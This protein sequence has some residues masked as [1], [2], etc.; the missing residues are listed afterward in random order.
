MH[1]N[2]L[3]LINFRNYSKV[4]LQLSPTINVF[5][6]P[7]GAGKTNLLDALHYVSFTKS[8]ISSTDQENIMH[9]CKF[10]N[11][12]AFIKTEHSEHDVK[13]I[14]Q[15][16]KRKQFIVDDSE[17]EKMSDHIGRFPSV[18]IQPA[19]NDLIRGASALRR[20]FFD[21][22]I[23]QYDHQY[24]EA[25]IRYNQAL[26]QRN[27][28]LRDVNRGA[29]LDEN[30][31]GIYTQHL[32]T[33]GRQIF[34]TRE[35]FLQRFQEIFNSEY[36][37]IS[38]DLETVSI[39]YES[40]LSE[41]DYEHKFNSALPEDIRK[42]RT[43]LGPHRDDFIFLIKN[44]PVR[45][46]GSQGQQKSFIIALKLA[47]FK[48]LL[49]ENGFKPLL[50]MDDIFDKLDDSRMKQLL[51]MID[52]GDFGQ[53]FITDARPERTLSLLHELGLESSIFEIAEGSAHKLETDGKKEG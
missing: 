23:S 35:S 1:I 11:I 10:F 13:C 12:S 18:L 30:L 5:I 26:R 48:I 3:Q 14:C 43:T 47:M 29:S 25:L 28:I 41:A 37:V 49:E 33:E 22:L 16:S 36:G 39:T 20:K 8:G 21:M 19:D 6:G 27:R 17:Y 32:L 31:M 34:S 50:L 51:S 45:K 40:S 9:E 53:V 52:H 42:E 7:N 38:G 2:E 4:K 46:E 15:L 44:Y 24:L